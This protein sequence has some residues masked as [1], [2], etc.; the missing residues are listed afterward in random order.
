MKT[1]EFLS[2]IYSA[3]IEARHREA[4]LAV[5]RHLARTKRF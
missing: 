2:R 5:E 4:R 1:P 3:M